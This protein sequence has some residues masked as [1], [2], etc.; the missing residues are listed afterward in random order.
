M[1]VILIM[2]GALVTIPKRVVKGLDDLEMRGQV[3]T[4]QI[5]ALSKSARILRRVLET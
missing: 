3:R 2:I 1:T 5:T 4:I